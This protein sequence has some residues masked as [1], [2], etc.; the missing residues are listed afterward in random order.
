[1]E[2]NKLF[3][4]YMKNPKK[5]LET[6][7]LNI[8]INI[9]F[10]ENWL[11]KETGEKAI[12]EDISI[13][14]WLKACELLSLE[15]GCISYGYNQ[16]LHKISIG[17]SLHEGHSR[18]RMNDQLREIY[19]EYKLKLRQERKGRRNYYSK[20]LIFKIRLKAFLLDIK[21]FIFR[22]LQRF[23]LFKQEILS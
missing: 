12:M 5:I 17:K 8:G 15:K 6:S 21:F 4:N 16:K 23:K 13:L 11:F 7:C 22:M 9:E 1:M 2:Q 19:R 10:L 14:H 20:K 18:L 3:F